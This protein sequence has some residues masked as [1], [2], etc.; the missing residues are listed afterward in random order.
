MINYLSLAIPLIGSGRVSQH[1]L[2]IVAPASLNFFT[3]SDIFF[4]VRSVLL[5]KNSFGFPVLLLLKIF[6]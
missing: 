3:N 5:P 6:V 4:G 2:R 1:S